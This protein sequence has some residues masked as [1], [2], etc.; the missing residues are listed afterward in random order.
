MPENLAIAKLKT[1]TRMQ[2]TRESRRFIF[3]GVLT[4]LIGFIGVNFTPLYWLSVRVTD[5]LWRAYRFSRH[6]DLLLVVIDDE[7]LTKLG[8]F[9]FDRTVYARAL[10]RLK[11]A[12][13]KVVVFDI[14]FVEPTPSDRA[15]AE[16]MRRFGK[17]ILG[18]NL[19][20]EAVKLKERFKLSINF[21]LP[22]RAT[23]VT[24]PPEPLLSACSGLGFVYPFPDKD[25]ICRTFPLAIELTDGKT[26]FPSLGL[27]AAIA[28]SG[29]PQMH[30]NAIRWRN[31]SI[32]VG[33]EWDIPVLVP[34]SAERVGFPSISLA[35]VLEGDFDPKA[36]QGKLVLVGMAA[37]GLLDRLPTPTDPLAYG[38]EIHAAVIN[39]LLTGQ[40]LRNAPYWLQ[41]LVATLFCVSVSMSV[42]MLPFQRSLAVFV[43]LVF[44]AYALPLFLL[45]RGLI[46]PPMLLFVSLVLAF[47]AATGLLVEIQWSALQRVKAYVVQPVMESLAFS[48]EKFRTGERL[49][50]TVLFSDIRNFTSVAANLSPYEVVTLLEAY[51]NRMT[52]IVHLYDGI[53]DKF[54]G[55]GMMVLFGVAPNQNDHAKRAVLCAWQML[56]ELSTVNWEWERITGS[57]LNIGIGIN[58]GIAIIGEIGAEWRKELTALGAT[59]NLA[60]RLEQLT[61]EVGAS[62]LISESTYQHVADLIT[63]E[64]LEPLTVKGFEQPILAY[65]VTGLTELGRE[66]RR[67]ILAGRT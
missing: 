20:S 33:S 66:T 62:L 63:A 57:P 21:P 41:L 46:L 3:V 12:G 54:L 36:I 51:F 56:E 48:P 11:E 22:L 8:R 25:G 30:P 9:P 14:L 40:T 35:K 53:V 45:Q 47:I 29:T 28:W 18:V 24:L 49:E 23:G 19:A 31:R 32:H 65:K 44:A 37:S 5:S 6:P 52:E 16:S 58:T 27:A 67:S 17:V 4:A 10:D 15:L 1:V 7:T 59:V 39:S 60:Q 43:G 13:A 42:L 26:A 55:D 61:K 50:V 34:F 2:R 38:V 64:P